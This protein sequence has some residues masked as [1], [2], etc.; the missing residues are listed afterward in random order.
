M[1]DPNLL[2]GFVDDINSRC[3]GTFKGKKLIRIAVQKERRL[4]GLIKTG[5]VKNIIYQL[6]GTRDIV[7][8]EKNECHPGVIMMGLKGDT[9]V[10]HPKSV[11]MTKY[12]E[13]FLDRVDLDWL[14]RNDFELV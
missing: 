7:Y 6:A 2:T 11:P 10:M 1:V 12:A 14:K 9:W 13:Y 4:F 3:P 8:K 5:S